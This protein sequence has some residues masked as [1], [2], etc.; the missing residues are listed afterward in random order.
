MKKNG[1]TLIELLAVI[2]ILA[3]IALIATPLVL[4]Y[5]EK[6]RKESKVDS[7]YSFVRNLETEIAN[8]SIKNNG[9]KYNGQPSDKG[10]YELSS[11][12]DSEID[13]TVKGDKPNSVKVCLSSLGQVEKAMFEYG[14]Y[15][16]S[17]DGKKG[18]I[19]DSDTYSSFTCSS[20][21]GGGT[22]IASTY[23]ID[24][25]L[26]FAYNESRRA[27]TAIL[28]ITKD[29]AEQFKE[30]IDYDFIIDDGATELIYAAAYLGSDLMFYSHASDISKLNGVIVN[31]ETIE[32]LS[33]EELTGV[34]NVKI[35]NARPIEESTYFV[36]YSDGSMTIVGYG[37]V[38][39]TAQIVIKDEKGTEYYNDNVELEDEDGDGI[40]GADSGCRGNIPNL[41]DVYT[42]LTNGK[43]ITIEIIQTVNGKEVI[44]AVTKNLNSMMVNSDAYFSRE[45]I[46]LLKS[47]GC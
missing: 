37:L 24:E 34:H 39:G 13:T 23:I 12:K 38:S 47:F 6:S 20:N 45:Y 11:F 29:I 18:S 26:E 32:F 10:Y 7:A 35:G 16:V 36:I 46:L 2:V 33:M 42:A 21:I 8:F 3:I 41:P 28:T 30:E 44:S 27:Y 4:K 19:S 40:I 25:D 31:E 9:K 15:Y 43:T 1:F 5:I 22:D 17:Y 14:K